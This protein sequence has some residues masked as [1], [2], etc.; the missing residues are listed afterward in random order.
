MDLIVTHK[1][2]K[3]Q[4]GYT[5]ILYLD[6]QLTEFATEF[7][8]K[9]E[10][11]KIDLN[12]SVRNYIK[13]KLPGLKIN[14]VNIMI[15]SILIASIPLASL[16]KTDL[17]QHQ[18]IK[19][20][21]QTNVIQSQINTNTPN[22]YT[23]KYG[24]TLYKIAKKFNTSIYDLKT[25]NDLDSDIIYTGQHLTI[26]A[27]YDIYSVE[28]GDTLF[29]IAA[30][31]NVSVEKLKSINKLNRNIIYVGQNLYVPKL[32]YYRYTVKTGDTLYIIAK[33]FD[34]TIEQIKTINKL[35][36]NIIYKGQTLRI[37]DFD[38]DTI[39]INP[40]SRLALVNKNNRLT[41]NY[42]PD[43]LVVPNIPF[44]YKEYYPKKLMR[45][46]AAYALEQLFNKA[47][48]DGIDLYATSGYRSYSYQEYI[49]TSKV[50]ERGI[51]I[52]NQTSAKPGESEHQ[53]GLAMD[54]TSP[55][56]N[57]R[58][59]QSFGETK[60]G[61]WLKANAHKYGFI[62]RYPVNKEHITGYNYEPWH[63][64]YVGKDV[65]KYIA[66]NDITLEEY[67]GEF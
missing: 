66:E 5:V 42:A 20:K 2:I 22:I 67:L 23:V 11:K 27:Q 35:S 56:V 34:V 10:N 12:T 58:L 9:P 46:D 51:N 1:L 48:E 30:V 14:T 32:L 41:E 19:E 44:P 31:Y 55:S 24:D 26:P 36:G 40:V 8:K 59:T 49:F 33:Q 57:F 64:R 25:I 13:E 50:M 18:N 37:P 6:N 54:V 65:A 61:K 45:E 15:G 39:V 17:N 62:I 3:E 60:E 38:K 29:E 53:T 4:E 28:P 63:I 52:A 7:N 21:L 47:E 16:G 43:N